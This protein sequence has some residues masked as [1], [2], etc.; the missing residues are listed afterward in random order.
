MKANKILSAAL[1]IGMTFSIAACGTDESNKNHDSE[2]PSGSEIT[3]ETTSET[4]NDSEKGKLGIASPVGEVYAYKDNVVKY[5]KAGE[6]AK[7]TDYYTS[8]DDAYSP[9]KIE[10]ENTYANV[11]KFV[12]EYSVNEDMSET[13]TAD[14][15]AKRNRLYVYNLLKGQKYYVRVTAKLKNG[16]EKIAVSEFETTDNGP[17][18]MK[19]DGIYNVRDLGGYI[20]ESGERTKQGLFFRGGALSGSTDPAYTNIAIGDKGK[21]YMREVLG[22]KTD[23]DLRKAAESLNIAES[24]IPNAN[25]EYYGV[26]GY[27]S[28]FTES[29]GYR[30]VFAALS[31]ESR[32][33]VYMHCT[34]GA[35]RTG[36]VSFL[37]NALVGVREADL[38]RDYEF[39]S[40]SKYGLRDSKGNIYQFKEFVEKLKTYDG[41]TLSE[42]TENYMLS[43][44][45]TETEIY[46]IK[47]IMLGKTVRTSSAANEA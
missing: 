25:L 47:A 21:K 46:N 38:I 24:P 27:L 1:A 11:E 44:G 39:T 41:E 7:I 43:I 3:S 23:F 6:N 16:S 19:I 42:K 18:V 29:E 34:G 32:Y 36:T 8:M 26:N 22:I 33:P 20:T 28:A 12:V 15:D 31:D 30:K 4:I 10:W 9:V 17:R 13:E 35:D 2:S 5:L 45:V 37:I 14:V 40:F